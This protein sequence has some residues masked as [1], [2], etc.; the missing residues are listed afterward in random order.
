MR[1]KLL[2]AAI[3]L[4]GCATVDADVTGADVT[5]PTPFLPAQTLSPGECGLFGYSTDTPPLFIFFA[6]SQGRALYHAGADETEILRAQGPF[7][8]SDYGSVALELGA[9]EAL[10]DGQRYNSARLVETL[11]DGFERVRPMVV[12]ESCG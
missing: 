3:L 2:I 5:A 10:I 12:L 7:P 11:D 1:A 9:A 6:S 4:T 8:S